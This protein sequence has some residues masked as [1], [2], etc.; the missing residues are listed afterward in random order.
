MNNKPRSREK[1]IVSGGSN[2]NRRGEGLGTGRVGTADSHGSRASGSSRT[3]TRAGG[4]IG[5][6]VLIVVVSLLASKLGLGSSDSYQQSQYP[7]QYSTQQT[8]SQPQSSAGSGSLFNTLPSNFDY[9]TAASDFASASHLS[10]KKGEV[11]TNV[12]DG[13]RAKYTTIKGNGDDTVTIMVYMCGTDLESNHGMGTADLSEMARADLFDNVNLI[14]YTGGCKRWK[15]QVV[16]S[17]HNQIYR[18]KNGG[19]NLLE[20]NMGDKPMTDPDTLTEFIAYCNKNYPADRMDLIFWDHGSGSISGYGYDEKHASA[21]SMSLS[22]INKALKNAGIKYDFIGFDACLMATVENA[23]M[24]SEY[25]DYLIASEETEP[26]VG[27][28]Y[29]NWLTQLSRNTS[30][31][32]LD[33]GKIIVD[34][35]IDVCDQKCNGQKTTL[36]VTDL[37]E[38]ANTVPGELTQFAK[39]TN[40]LI[41][42]DDYKSVS[43][44]RNNTKEFAQSSKIDQI[45]FIH[46]AKNINTEEG[47]KLAGVL[48]DA[49][50]YNRTAPC[51][52]DAYGLSIYFP[53]KKASKVDSVVRTYND[54]GMDEEY[55]RCI[56]E[57]AS[58]EVSGQIAQG[59]NNS[60]LTSILPGYSSSSSA[61]GGGYGSILSMLNAMSQ[62]SS[63]S[64]TG[65]EGIDTLLMSFLSDRSMP[66]EKA[67]QYLSDNHFDADMLTW[68]GSESVKKIT[69]PE[70]Q[71]DMVT[72]IDLNVFYDDGEGYVDLGLDNIY[73]IEGNDLI[74]E[75]DKTWLSI[76]GQIVAYYHTDTVDDGS[77]YSIFG[78]VPALLNGERVELQIVF[79]NENPNGYITGAKPVYTNNETDTVAKSAIG[80][81]KGDKIDF[82]CDFYTYDGE[83]VD[84]YMLGEQMV[85][86]DTVTIGNAYVGDGKT[87]ATYR[88]TDIYEQHYWTDPIE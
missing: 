58:L 63:E 46:F 38:L 45:D 17:S 59:G 35:F 9:S 71:L 1:N 7:S 54:I 77:N 11:N 67:A 42:N 18:V 26:G 4:G 69:L 86:G 2:V 57:F 64:F 74:G 6:I 61:A 16:S 31:S 32:T 5:M 51:V 19:L 84:S 13:S 44:A 36:S 25:A 73:T 14:V 37:A 40:E 56:Q 79:D 60:P 62:Q 20:E 70:D 52:R 50:K 22:G 68:T 34:D 83:Y 30:M 66:E 24:L 8:A 15:N 72:G 88:F 3:V 23:L 82:I 87:V 80:L 43:I 29:T 55:A 39:A 49:V 21:G 41:Q 27:W 47:R 53:L 75:Y 85:L 33:I 81:V 78:Y 12:A 48:T 10:A 76:N 28:Y 65:A